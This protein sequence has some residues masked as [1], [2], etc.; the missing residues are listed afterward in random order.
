MLLRTPAS[1]QPALDAMRDGVLR[2][3]EF[4]GTTPRADFWWFVIAVAMVLAL[5]R[6]VAEAVGPLPLQIASLLVLVPWLAA[7]TRRLRDAGLLI[8]VMTRGPT[9][10]ERSLLRCSRLHRAYERA[11]EQARRYGASAPESRML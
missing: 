3:L 4:R 1:G 7:C 5:V 6:I 8:Q 2:G 9:H 10:V 11:A